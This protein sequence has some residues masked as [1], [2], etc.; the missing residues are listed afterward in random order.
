MSH[1]FVGDQYIVIATP[2]MKSTITEAVNPFQTDSIEGFIN[3]M[4]VKGNMHVVVTSTWCP[5]QDTQIPVLVTI[6]T[7]KSAHDYQ[8]HF[9]PFF[10]IYGLTRET[11]GNFLKNFP[12][13]TSDFADPIRLGFFKA[14][15]SFCLSKYSRGLAKQEKLLMYRFC[16]VHFKRNLCRVANISK[17][18]NL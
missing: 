3:P 12:G 4:F 16:E 2:G 1:S 10:E 13:N 17:A 18:V 9:K 7:N 11:I 15:N 14:A 5:Y 8:C 6:L